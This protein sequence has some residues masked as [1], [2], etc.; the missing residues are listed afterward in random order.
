VASSAFVA[1]FGGSVWALVRA[2]EAQGF[3]RCWQENYEARFPEPAE[4]ASFFVTAAGPAA[5]RL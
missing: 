4:R 1:C 5:M 2:S 3:M